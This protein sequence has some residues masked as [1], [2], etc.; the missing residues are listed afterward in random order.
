MTFRAPIKSSGRVLKIIS[1]RLYQCACG[2]EAASE[3]STAELQGA[4]IDKCAIGPHQVHLNTNE[5]EIVLLNR[6]PMTVFAS[7][8][9]TVNRDASMPDHL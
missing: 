6:V 5:D 3:T 9:I 2:F 1:R 4:R 7:L 8:P